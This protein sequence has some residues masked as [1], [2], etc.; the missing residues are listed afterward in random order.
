MEPVRVLTRSELLARGW[1]PSELRR[2]RG[3]SQLVSIRRGAYARADPR[4]SD[5]RE[6]HLVRVGAAARAMSEQ[7]VVSHVSAAVLY[8][9]LLWRADLSRV[10]ITRARG[11][12]GRISSDVHVTP[13][14]LDAEEVVLVD[15]LRVTSPARTVV[16]L[17]RGLAFEQGV[18]VA[19][20]ALRSGLVDAAA[21]QAAV[22]RARGWPGVPRA[23]RAVAFADGRSESVG[24]SRS[25]VAIARA[26][27][28]APQPQLEVFDRQHVLVGR[29]DFGWTER[30]TVGEFDGKLKYERDLAP[31]EEA[32]KVVFTEKCREDALRDCDL[33]VARWVWSELRDFRP[34]V[35]RIERAFARAARRRR[36]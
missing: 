26:G 34:V 29:C 15:G 33:E 4:L 27:L 21:L 7:A 10:H 18:V 31:D 20:S 3:T 32:G 6:L 25:R 1:E 28:P 23:R 2:L 13:A 14:P 9:F 22:A 19:D 36:P 8:G 11:R 24:E 30:H 5:P 16:D 17:L 12:G 35:R